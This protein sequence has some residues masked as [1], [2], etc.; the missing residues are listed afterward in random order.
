MHWAAT[1][2]VCVGHHPTTPG[3]GGKLAPR[4]RLVAVRPIWH[5]QKSEVGNRPR[6][7]YPLSAQPPPRHLVTSDDFA[8]TAPCAMVP[9][10]GPYPLVANS[11]VGVKQGNAFRE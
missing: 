5:L 3:R 10:R 8:I 6:T 1:S 7:V 2:G 9:E 4:I 11:G